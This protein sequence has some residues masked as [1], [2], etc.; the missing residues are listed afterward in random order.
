MSGRADVR[1][2]ALRYRRG[3]EIA[4]AAAGLDEGLLLTGDASQNTEA[5][6]RSAHR[7]Q[8][9][10]LLLRGEREAEAGVASPGSAASRGGP[11]PA[12]A[13]AQQAAPVG[14]SNSRGKSKS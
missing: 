3:R 6:Q 9:V 4:T 11:S 12:S 2:P 13:P 14:A 5:Q 1:E 8:L 10:P 7:G